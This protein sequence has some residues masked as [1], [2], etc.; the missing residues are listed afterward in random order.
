[1]GW[2]FVAGLVRGRGLLTVLGGLIF[3]GHL[4]K[5]EIINHWLTSEEFIG[6]FF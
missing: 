6:A 2:L 5:I 4:L 3:L 1:M